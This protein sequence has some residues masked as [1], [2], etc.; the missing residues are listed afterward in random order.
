[1]KFLLE[2]LPGNQRPPG[3]FGKGSVGLPVDPVGVSRE[4][5]SAH[6]VILAPRSLDSHRVTWKIGGADTP[7]VPA[8]VPPDRVITWNIGGSLYQVSANAHETVAADEGQAF[9]GRTPYR[10]GTPNAES[11]IIPRLHWI[12]LSSHL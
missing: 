12:L 6:P 5:R 11:S 7:T 2:D 8:P 3:R 10:P 1:M 9:G 4:H